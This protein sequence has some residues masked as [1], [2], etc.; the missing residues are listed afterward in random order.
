MIDWRSIAKEEKNNTSDSINF[1][2]EKE[3]E[4]EL[5]KK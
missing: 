5:E 1:I 2:I 3:K 4:L